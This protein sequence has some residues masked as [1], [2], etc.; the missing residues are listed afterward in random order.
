MSNQYENNKRIAKNT[1]QYYNVID[2]GN[3]IINFKNYFNTL[4]IEDYSIYNV[5]GVGAV[6][7]FLKRR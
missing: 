4:G 7:V 6:F 1:I 3:N 2:N 5:V